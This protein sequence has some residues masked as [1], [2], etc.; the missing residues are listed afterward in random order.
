MSLSH[1]KS[2]GAATRRHRRSVR[3]EDISTAAHTQAGTIHAGSAL[4]AR[5][6]VAYDGQRRHVLR[7]PHPLHL[8]LQVSFHLLF[9]FTHLNQRVVTF[10]RRGRR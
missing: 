1:V 2:G 8:H 5:R 9:T 3:A 6:H 10:V 4:P 7:S